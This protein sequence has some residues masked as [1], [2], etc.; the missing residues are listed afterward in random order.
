[1]TR[2]NVWQPEDDADLSAAVHQAVGSA[3]MAWVETPTGVF[4]DAWARAVADGLIAWVT[5]RYT[6][7]R[8]SEAGC[9]CWVCIQKQAEKIEDYTQRLGFLSRMIVCPECGNKRCPRATWHENACTGSNDPQQH[10]SRYGG[11]E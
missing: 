6:P 9:G 1:M 7:K 2:P 5:E 4:D 3:S 8:T 11:L 10:G